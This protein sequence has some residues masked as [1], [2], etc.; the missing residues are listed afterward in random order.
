VVADAIDRAA[1]LVNLK[2]HQVLRVRLFWKHVSY[3][4]WNKTRSPRV[5][6]ARRNRRAA[7][8]EFSG[9]DTLAATVRARC[10]L[11]DG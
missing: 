2:E 3:L 7:K 10:V 5:V 8:P 4:C 11:I 6:S 9:G 1:I